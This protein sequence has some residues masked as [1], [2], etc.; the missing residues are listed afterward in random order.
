MGVTQT[1]GVG[2]V[3]PWGPQTPH[4]PDAACNLP[5]ASGTLIPP[6]PSAPPELLGFSSVQI[7]VV[8]PPL[9]CPQ[10]WL[11]PAGEEAQPPGTAEGF[12][13]KLHLLQ[14]SNLSTFLQT[15]ETTKHSREQIRI[16]GSP[17][18]PRIPTPI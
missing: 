12:R 15:G 18:S 16:P 13:R 9:V 5:V 11:N 4:L 14:V 17:G 1:A 10:G 6:C 2:S 3:P 8:P 7:P